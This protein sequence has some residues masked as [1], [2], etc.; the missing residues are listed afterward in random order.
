MISSFW[1]A[2]SVSPFGTDF[3]IVTA[4]VYVLQA[5][6]AA[7]K[8]RPEV[9]SVHVSLPGLRGAMLLVKI[10]ANYLESEILHFY[11]VNDGLESKRSSIA[12]CE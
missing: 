3:E 6:A 12:T 2:L 5:V 1:K 10:S 9:A 4:V 11:R 7:E 8:Y